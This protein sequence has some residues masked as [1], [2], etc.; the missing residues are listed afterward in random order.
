MKISI[1]LPAYP[2]FEPQFS[3]QSAVAVLARKV[4]ATA[5]TVF[6]P[7]ELAME[8]GIEQEAVA[9]IFHYSCKR[10]RV[11]GKPSCV[12]RIAVAHHLHNSK[13]CRLETRFAFRRGCGLSICQ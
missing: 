2:Y 11:L 3:G 9:C 8:F 6:Y 13:R 5:P 12:E 1:L 10:D 7:V 4:L